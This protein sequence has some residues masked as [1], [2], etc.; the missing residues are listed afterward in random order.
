MTGL[1]VLN[2]GNGANGEP[3]QR[4]AEVGLLCLWHRQ[5][6]TGVLVAVR[7][8]W[9]DLAFIDQAGSAPKDEAPKTAYT[10]AAEAP[11][12]AN[13]EPRTAR[14]R[15]FYQVRDERDDAW[16]EVER[17]RALIASARD[18]LGGTP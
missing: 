9:I 5:R 2:H 14:Y 4:E 18:I 15:L 10:K 6:L 7:E 8:L 17:L 11:A 16:R 12:P 3:L 13:L 1:C